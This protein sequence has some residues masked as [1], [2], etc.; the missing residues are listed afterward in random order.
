MKAQLKS[1]LNVVHSP[2]IQYRI[3]PMDKNTSALM[4]GTFTIYDTM[5]V[6]AESTIGNLYT[7]DQGKVDWAVK[8][9]ERLWAQSATPFDSQNII[10]SILDRLHRQ[11]S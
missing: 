1:L 6:C 4:D 9:F 11:E 8:L 3:I 10:L 7:G 5:F 2:H